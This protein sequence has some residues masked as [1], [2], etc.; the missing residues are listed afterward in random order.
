LVQAE[1]TKKDPYGENFCAY[2]TGLTCQPY[3]WQNGV[4]TAL[5]LLGGNNGSVGAINKYGEAAGYAENAIHDAACPAGVTVNGTGPQVL[6]FKPVIWGP[7]PGQ[8]RELALLPGDTVGVAMWLNDQGQAA[9]VSGTCANTLYP[10]A[11]AGPHAVLWDKDGSVHDLGSLGGTVNTSV[12]FVGNV[13]LSINNLGQVVGASALP[14]N[15]TNH[16]FLWT[17]EAGMQDLGTLPGDVQSGGLEINDRGEVV[18]ASIDEMGNARA[19]L[20]RKGV[21]TDLNTMIPEN[22]P[23]Y[24]LLPAMI[25]SRGEI[26]GFGVTNEGDI[27]AFLATPRHGGDSGGSATSAEDERFGRPPLPESVRAMVRSK[28]PTGPLGIGRRTVR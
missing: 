5:P 3:L 4:M 27:H 16:A 21:M 13:G 22:S 12:M 8:I 11:T 2:G 23:L 24:L 28:L 7:A 26:V 19:F 6:D 20:W 9:G 18:G 10:P 25:N 17:S 1:S 15:T 14:G